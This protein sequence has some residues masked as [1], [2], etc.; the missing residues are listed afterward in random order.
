M[1]GPQIL[2]SS[3]K[4]IDSGVRLAMELYAAHRL[5]GGRDVL[6]DVGND[7]VALVGVSDRV[8]PAVR[9]AVERLAAALRTRDQRRS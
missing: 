1:L 8:S 5:P 6:L 4:R 7:G 2:A 3:V 9:I